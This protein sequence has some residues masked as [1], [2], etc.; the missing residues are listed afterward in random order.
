MFRMLVSLALALSLAIVQP[1]NPSAQD[2]PPV[3]GIWVL[4][5]ITDP[6][7]QLIDID[8]LM[9]QNLMGY[10]AI[11]IV[12]RLSFDR[13]SSRTEVLLQTGPSGPYTCTATVTMPVELTAETLVIPTEA[14]ATAEYRRIEPTAEGD[15]R[16]IDED[17]TATLHAG[18]YQLSWEGET[19]LVT[20]E[21]VVTRFERGLLH[22]PYR[23]Y[24]AR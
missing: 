23:D 20:R 8:E 5:S 2:V 18:S 10:L 21:G 4:Q 1:G 22:L 7:G 15:W 3:D 24:L 13:L 11:H 6:E 14:V 17:C 9:E 16:D 12:W 19:L